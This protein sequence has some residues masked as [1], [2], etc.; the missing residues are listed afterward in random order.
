MA[1]SSP[2]IF[3]YATHLDAQGQAYDMYRWY[4]PLSAGKGEFGSWEI[5]LRKVEGVLTKAPVAD[6]S[7]SAERAIWRE[8]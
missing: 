5:M 3:K 2:L 8:C 7:S 4:L 6:I 1:L